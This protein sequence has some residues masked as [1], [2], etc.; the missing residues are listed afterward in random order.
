MTVVSLYFHPEAL[1]GSKLAEYKPAQ[2]Q[3]AGDRK[4]AYP[5]YSLPP[6][7]GDGM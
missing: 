3:P 6:S 7:T 1:D 5:L 2:G 4:P